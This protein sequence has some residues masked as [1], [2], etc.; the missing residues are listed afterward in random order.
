MRTLAL[1]TWSATQRGLRNLYFAFKSSYCFRIG[2]TH[3]EIL[4]D[5]IGNAR[6]RELA[7]F[8]TTIS[9]AKRLMAVNELSKPELPRCAL[10]TTVSATATS[11][12][13]MTHL[14]RNLSIFPDGW[15]EVADSERDTKG[16][17]TVS[18]TILEARRAP[19]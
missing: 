13:S 6:Y 12:D 19:G 8:G 14:A 15:R 7:T 9:V 10:G 17:G 16:V 11:Q 5:Y 3:G 2:V 1:W 4:V 18:V